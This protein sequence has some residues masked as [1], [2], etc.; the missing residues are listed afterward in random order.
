MVGKERE[1]SPL[2]DLSLGCCRSQPQSPPKSTHRYCATGKQFQCDETP[3]LTPE[4]LR[5]KIQQ[6]LLMNS[7]KKYYYG[8]RGQM[9]ERVADTLKVSHTGNDG[10]QWCKVCLPWPACKHTGHWVFLY[11]GLKKR[12]FNSIKYYWSLLLSLVYTLSMAPVVSQQP[13]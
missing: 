1:W 12:I 4:S 9:A 10:A 13:S 8:K 5:R 2:L 7:I 6:D 3:A 11:F